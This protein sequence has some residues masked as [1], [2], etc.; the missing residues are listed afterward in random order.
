[1]KPPFPYFGSKTSIAGQIVALMPAHRVYLEPYTGSAAVFL[2]KPPCEHEYLN[3][4]NAAVVAFFRTLRDQRAEL[5]E[6]CRLTPYAR[7]EYLAADLEEQGLE[8]LELAR[9]W[10]IRSSA[11]FSGIVNAGQVN[12][13]AGSPATQASRARTVRRRL[14]RIHQVAD[15]LSGAVIDNRDAL[16]AIA[17]FGNRTDAVIYV[18]PPYF[19]ETRAG[20]GGYLVDAPDEAHHRALAAALHASPAAVILSGYDSP[21]YL[22]LFA[23]WHRIDLVVDS[24]AGGTTG[25][26]RARTETLWLNY[27]PHEGTL[28]G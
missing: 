26:D 11:S 1:M 15:R 13:S 12:F 7:D 24:A 17:L 25:T 19:D 5:V 16:E 9:R 22:E 18:D 27:T 2:A 4:A 23:D 8:P 10:W 6:A 28:F 21:L 14:E 20:P 3:D